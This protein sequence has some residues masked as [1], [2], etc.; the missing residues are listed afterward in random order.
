MWHDKSGKEVSGKE[1]ISRWKDG[2]EKVTPLQTT[3]INLFGYVIV[4]LGIL[5]GLYITFKVKQW[6]LFTVLCG[7]F[8]ITS[9]AV[10]GQLQKYAL[11][12]KLE[13]ELNNCKEVENGK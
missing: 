10:I 8:I 5:W 1:F 3:K 11:F 7:S 12:S 2:I 9:T 13:I 4:F 6:W